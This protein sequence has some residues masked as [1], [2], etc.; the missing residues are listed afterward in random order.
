MW[1]V[2]FSSNICNG[3]ARVHCTGDIY[4]ALLCI[5]TR[6]AWPIYMY[7]RVNDIIERREKIRGKGENIIEKRKKRAALSG[8]ETWYIVYGRW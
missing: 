2:Y 5:V 6:V 1:D 4:N 7:V 3:S 8:V